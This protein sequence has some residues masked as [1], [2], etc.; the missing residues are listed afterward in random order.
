[1]PKILSPV[2][3]LLALLVLAPAAIAATGYKIGPGD[4]LQLE[5]LEDPSLNRSLLVLPDGNIT[6]PFGGVIHAGGMTVSEARAAVAQVL[7]PNFA[8]APTV[9]LAVS[10]LATKV[11]GTGTSHGTLAVYLMGEVT[12]PGRTDV[13]PGTTLLQFLAQ[14]GGLTVFA[15]T[16]RIQLRRVDA[17]GKEQVYLFNYDAI[18]AGGQSAAI[19]LQKGDVIIVPQRR[20]FE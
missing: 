19:S 12:K 7:A 8:K 5:V 1:M 18:L 14:S 20:L 3:A 9:N 4:L 13:E 6:V 10:Q 11:A 2:L 17:A 16:K 15:A